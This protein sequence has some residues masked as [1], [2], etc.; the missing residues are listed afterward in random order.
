M[1]KPPEG[2]CEFRGFS[3][4]FLGYEVTRRLARYRVAVLELK[5]ETGEENMRN[6]V[7]SFYVD[8]LRRP[9]ADWA[10]SIHRLFPPSKTIDGYEQSSAELQRRK[11]EKPLLLFSSF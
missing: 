9:I 1:K 5:T 3:K 10:A 4:N 8:V 2:G 6:V 7:A 11:K